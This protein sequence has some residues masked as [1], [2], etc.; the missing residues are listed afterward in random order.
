MINLSEQAETGQYLR[1]R[2][3]GGELVP[4]FMIVFSETGIVVYDLDENKRLHA[5]TW[6]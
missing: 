4:N 1:I 2:T 3:Y 6:D 5:V